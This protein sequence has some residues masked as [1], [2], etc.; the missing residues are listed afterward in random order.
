MVRTPT[1]VEPLSNRHSIDA[2]NSYQAE[3]GNRNYLTTTSPY[4]LNLT[5]PSVVCIPPALPP[6]LRSFML[7]RVTE[8]PI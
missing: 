2:V 7:A 5:G 3:M 1:F 8:L 4:K 6:W